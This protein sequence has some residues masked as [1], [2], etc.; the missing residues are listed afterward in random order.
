MFKYIL[1][2]ILLLVFIGLIILGL[3]KIEKV[4]LEDWR[5]D[6]YEKFKTT[7]HPNKRILFALIQLGL[8]IGTM[9]I[10]VIPANT[11]R[12]KY[13]KIGWTSEKT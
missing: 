12:V 2:I 13:S 3:L 4:E 8:W 7:F 6:S 10:A 1:Q 11:V 9:C 5:G